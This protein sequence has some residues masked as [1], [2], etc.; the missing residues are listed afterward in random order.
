M[1]YLH[2]A[3]LAGTLYAFWLL[4]SGITTPF[5]VSAGLA[6]AI[7]VAALARRMEVADR[8]G[9]PIHLV[10]AALGYWPWLALQIAKSGFTVA[11]IV[12]DPKLPVSPVMVRFRPLQETT[13]GLATHANSITLTPGTITVE[14]RHG[15]FLVHALTREA[16]AGLAGGEMDRR[17][18]RFEAGG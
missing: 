11:R 13:L 5:L 9:H 1:R 14:A 18:R 6:C 4:M 17:V 3:A 10:P 2:P 12:L 8:E 7:G 16:A 15:E